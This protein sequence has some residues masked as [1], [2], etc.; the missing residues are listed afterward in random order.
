M[1]IGASVD[2]MGIHYGC[3]II[4]VMDIMDNGYPLWICIIS[5]VDIMNIHYVYSLWIPVSVDI[6]DIH[7]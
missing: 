7:S 4:S 6:M 5:I 3:P 2:V 1:G